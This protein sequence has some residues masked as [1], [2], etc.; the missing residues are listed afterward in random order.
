MGRNEAIDRIHRTSLKDSYGLWGME[1]DKQVEHEHG[2][3]I[4]WGNKWWRW[5]HHETHDFFL[6]IIIMELKFVIA[7]KWEYSC[8][9]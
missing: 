7:C 2:K 1:N 3:K 5:S 8:K 9:I 6:C 4:A